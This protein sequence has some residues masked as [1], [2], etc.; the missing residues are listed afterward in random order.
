MLG[1]TPGLREE[2]TLMKW[3]ELS[4]V[5]ALLSER[6]RKASPASNRSFTR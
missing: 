3:L 2:R 6:L 1:P 4:K 5:I